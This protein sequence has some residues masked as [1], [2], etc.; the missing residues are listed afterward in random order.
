MCEFLY[1]YSLFLKTIL[2]GKHY[3]SQYTHEK[4]VANISLITD[5]SQGVTVELEFI[6][7][8]PCCRVLTKVKENKWK[9]N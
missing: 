9:R 5:Q 1:I 4:I 8:Q 3:A 2:W 7:V 6:F